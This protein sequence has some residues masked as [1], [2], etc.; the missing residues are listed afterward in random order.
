MWDKTPIMILQQIKRNILVHH[1]ETTQT[2]EKNF[3]HNIKKVTDEKLIALKKTGTYTFY[4]HNQNQQQQ[5][6]MKKISIGNIRK[7]SDRKK[8]INLIEKRSISNKAKI[9]E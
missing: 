1:E 2:Q 4:K 5:L 7:T 8:S 9:N 3:R 6:R